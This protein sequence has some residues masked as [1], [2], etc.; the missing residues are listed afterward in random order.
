MRAVV[1]IRIYSNHMNSIDRLTEAF[2]KFPGIGPRQARR[3]V[4]HLLR[5]SKQNRTFMAKLIDAIDKDIT[6]CAQCMRF[7]AGTGS[8]CGICGN[9]NR[10]KTKLVIVS[11]D[12]DV[13]AVEKCG[14]YNGIYF[15]L[16][17]TLPL[18]PKKN[19]RPLR[20][21]ELFAQIEKLRTDGPLGEIILALNATADGENTVYY[22]KEKIRENFNDGEIKLSV[23]GRGLSSGLEIE[24]SDPDTIKS[25]IENR[26]SM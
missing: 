25:A 14:M 4:F 2:M 16:G 21:V 19:M 22:L 9:P 3:F 11:R 15:V 8:V 7:F 5:E 6:Q 1:E 18:V 24:Y 20:E 10:D 23:L 12:S 17:G 26:S 13:E